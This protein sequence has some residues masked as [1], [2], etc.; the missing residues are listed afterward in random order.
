ML[1]YFQYKSW[2]QGWESKKIIEGLLSVEIIPTLESDAEEGYLIKFLEKHHQILI[3]RVLLQEPT[4]KCQKA[5]N[6]STRRE[7]WVPKRIIMSE[8]LSD[9]HINLAQRGT[10]S[11]SLLSALLQGI[12]YWKKIKEN[13]ANYPQYQP[14][15]LDS[16]N[17][18]WE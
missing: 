12:G 14:P 3:T 17:R 11:N 7:S 5:V 6:H 1:L 16:G 4:E 15:S 8:E 13:V 9:V 10:E 18:Y 2:C